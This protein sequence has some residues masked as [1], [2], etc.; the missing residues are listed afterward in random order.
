MRGFIIHISNKKSVPPALWP[1]RSIPV[2]VHPLPPS[3]G[4][5][6][7][8]T[9]YAAPYRGYQQLTTSHRRTR[10]GYAQGKKRNSPPPG[11]SC[12]PKR[13]YQPP[14]VITSLTYSAV[15]VPLLSHRGKWW[16]E[17]VECQ[18]GHK[19][20]S[21]WAAGV[22]TVRLLQN[23]YRVPYM[24]VYE[25]KL[26]DGAACRPPPAALDWAPHRPYHLW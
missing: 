15:F 17:S 2:S 5:S 4:S 12:A 23:R 11:A 22:R 8:F 20:F 18:Q 13:R 19:H 26:E 25:V 6:S 21:G 9:L 10:R 7:V 16:V 14:L 1:G 24:A 3:P